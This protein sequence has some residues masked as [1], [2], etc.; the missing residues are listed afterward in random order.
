MGGE[1]GGTAAAQY[2]ATDKHADSNLDV[3]I[4][5]R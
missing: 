3:Q 4:Q 1:L 2:D 5:L